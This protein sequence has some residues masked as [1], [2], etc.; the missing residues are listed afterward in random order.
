AHGGARGGV[1][2]PPAPLAARRR[3]AVRLLRGGGLYPGPAAQRAEPRRRPL[4]HGPP[5][6]DEPARAGPPPARPADA[7]PLRGRALIPGHRAAAAGA[8]PPGPRPASP[9]RR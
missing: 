3:G 5:R 1:P 7:A 4:V 8:A 6:G 2:Q 9:D